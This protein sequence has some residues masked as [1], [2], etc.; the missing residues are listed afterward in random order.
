MLP[1]FILYSPLFLGCFGDDSCSTGDPA[2]VGF[3]CPLIIPHRLTHKTPAVDSSLSGT[4]GT[5]DA[6]ECPYTIEVNQ[7][8]LMSIESLLIDCADVPGDI[9]ELTESELFE[10]EEDDDLTFEAFLNSKKDF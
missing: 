1:F 2:G 5:Q 3:D 8:H 9:F 10:S 4:G 7:T 6:L